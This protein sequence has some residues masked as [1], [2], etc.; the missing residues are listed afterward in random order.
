M[1]KGYI[2][3]M[4]NPALQDMVKIG[5]QFTFFIVEDILI[6]N[7]RRQLYGQ[8]LPI[9]VLMAIGDMYFYG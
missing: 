4:T 1:A 7:K 5:F 8:R 3:I 2:Y 6:P 9:Q